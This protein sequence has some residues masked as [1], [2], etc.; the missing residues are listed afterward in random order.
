MVQSGG[1]SGTNGLPKQLASSMPLLLR[2]HTY[3]PQIP[4]T[5]RR[6]PPLQIEVSP[7][8]EDYIRDL[9]GEVLVGEGLSARRS[10]SCSQFGSRV[11][12]RAAWHLFRNDHQIPPPPPSVQP[13]SGD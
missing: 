5:A 2:A 12:L 9:R 11:L 1:L 7:A 4:I 10:H 6:L 13:K 3:C 8:L